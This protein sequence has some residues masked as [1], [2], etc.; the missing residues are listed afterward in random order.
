MYNPSVALIVA[1]AAIGVLVVVFWPDKGLFQRWQRSRRLTQRVLREDA[2]KHIHRAERGGYRPTVQSVA[3][4]LDI[5]T[6]DAAE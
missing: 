6:N 1:L 4:D 5:S 3:G 2:L